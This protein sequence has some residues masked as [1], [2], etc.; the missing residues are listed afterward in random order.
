MSSEK[1]RINKFLVQAGVAASR[2]QAEELLLKA[3]VKIK[4]ENGVKV[5][6]AQLIGYQVDPASDQVFVDGRPVKWQSVKKVYLM[7][8]KP[9]GYV[10][11]RQDKYADKIVLDLLPVQYKKAGIFTV[12]RLDKESE[13]S[14]H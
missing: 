10:C 14:F 12:G 5:P 9:R 3:R 6:A 11:T 7:M 1:I 8:N 4:Q 13:G 2:R